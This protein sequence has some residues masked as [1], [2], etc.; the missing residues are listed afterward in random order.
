MKK[1]ATGRPFVKGVVAFY[2]PQ[3]YW[4]KDWLQREYVELKRS[5]GDIA[6]QFNVHKMAIHHWLRKHQIPRR[7]VSEA[8][9][10]KRWGLVGQ[11]NHMYGKRGPDATNYIDGSSDERG[12][13]YMRYEGRKVIHDTYA[14]DGFKCVRCQARPRGPRS[15]HA[16]HI[17]PWAGN[18]DLRFEPSN[19][20]TLCR[21]CHEWVH[22]KA[23]AEREF[24]APVGKGLRIAQA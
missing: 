8:R 22:S 6:E 9:A 1:Q 16:H 2:K 23:N 7:T 15:L 11:A 17:R 13:L 21:A 12:R 10:V 24:L 19:L 20:V 14:R 18:P 4:N 5:A 3:P